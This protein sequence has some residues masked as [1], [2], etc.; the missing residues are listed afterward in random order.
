MIQWRKFESKRS[1]KLKVMNFSC[2]YIFLHF[3]FIFQEF[4]EIKIRRKRFI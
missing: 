2:L 4:L 3:I 1:F